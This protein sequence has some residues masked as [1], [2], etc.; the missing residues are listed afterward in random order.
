MVIG[1]SSNALCSDSK[2]RVLARIK[3]NFYLETQSFRQRIHDATEETA[4]AKDK[5]DALQ[6]SLI[7]WKK[8][9]VKLQRK[10]EEKDAALQQLQQRRD[11]QFPL[12]FDETLRSVQSHM[13]N[14]SDDLGSV[15]VGTRCLRVKE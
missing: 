15:A 7:K 6:E 2:E 11:V 9:S 1:R 10:L 14:Q 13:D 4:C 3:H 8:R 12:L 5:V